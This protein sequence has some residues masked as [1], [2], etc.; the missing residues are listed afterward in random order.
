MLKDN[1]LFGRN[2]YLNSVIIESEKNYVGKIIKVNINAFNQNSLFGN[3]IN[4]KKKVA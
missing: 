3:I 1:K 4:I 2:K